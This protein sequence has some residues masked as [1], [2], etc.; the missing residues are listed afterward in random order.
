M[1]DVIFLVYANQ[2]SSVLYNPITPGHDKDDST[3]RMYIFRSGIFP[4]FPV[5]NEC[6][7]L[8]DILIPVVEITKKKN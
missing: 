5:K 6:G 3:L 2:E 4:K 7:I 1:H 8:S